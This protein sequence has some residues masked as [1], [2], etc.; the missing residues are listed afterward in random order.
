MIINL[1]L[2]S[3]LMESEGGTR[4]RALVTPEPGP[5]AL[6]LG[7]IRGLAAVR[8]FAMD[9]SLPVFERNE[10]LA[11][12]ETGAEL[13]F[14]GYGRLSAKGSFT[15][16]EL[17]VATHFR[18]RHPGKRAGS[19]VIRFSPVSDLK[20]L[21]R[22]ARDAERLKGGKVALTWQRFPSDRW[23]ECSEP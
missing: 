23:S 11:H 21:R 3:S 8:D 16:C 22:S 18:A 13:I 12:R 6:L 2:T 4:G 7:W 1:A 17:A 5:L 14:E 19:D 20:S 9:D 10:R 15:E